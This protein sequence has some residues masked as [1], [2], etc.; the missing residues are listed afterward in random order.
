MKLRYRP[1]TGSLY[2]G[3]TSTPGTDTR[4][5][6]GGLNVD[7]DVAGG[8]VGFAIDAVWHAQAC[9]AGAGRHDEAQRGLL[10]W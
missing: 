5:I 8:V 2:I 9:E 7:Q 1:D 3:F 4:A 6:A 10:R